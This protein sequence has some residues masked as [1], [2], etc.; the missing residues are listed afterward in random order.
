[1]WTILCLSGHWVSAYQIDAKLT[2]AVTLS[3][4]WVLADSRI[5]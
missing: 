1:V 5:E 4:D 3:K 2:C